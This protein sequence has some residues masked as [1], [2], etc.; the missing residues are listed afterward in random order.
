[1]VLE[2][3]NLLCSI[4]Q[5]YYQQSNTIL[6]LLFS[7]GGVINPSPLQLTL[8]IFFFFTKN[9]FGPLTMTQQNFNPTIFWWGGGHQSSPQVFFRQKKRILNP[10]LF[11]S[12]IFLPKIFSTKVCFSTKIFFHPKTS[13]TQKKFWHKTY[14]TQ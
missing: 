12:K 5:Q 9:L 7:G 11:Y 14:L 13:L 2:V 6:T 10:N 1:M 4:A 8:P 3:W